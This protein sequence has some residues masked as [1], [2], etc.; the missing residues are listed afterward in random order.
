MTTAQDIL[1]F[2][3]GAPGEPDAGKERDFW[4]RK[5]DSTD[6]LIRE[7]FGADVEAAL[8]GA[9]DHWA[10][11]V[12]GTRALILLL[13]QFTRN[14]F[15]GTP[16]AFAGD[17]R[18]LELARQLVAAGADRSL[19][20]LARWF[21]YLP[22]EHSESIDVQRESLRLFGE[23]AA[24]GLP[25]GLVWARKHYDVIAHFGRYPHRNAMLG[26]ASTAEELEYLAQPG[27]GF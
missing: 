20:P 26:R 10:Q 8:L 16:R 2:W 1:D 15:R 6:A 14:I 17:A 24:A 11:T 12:D 27:A 3:F 23:L 13:D 22:F 19:A 7:R 18:A 9:R 4:F 21:I 25:A 5:S